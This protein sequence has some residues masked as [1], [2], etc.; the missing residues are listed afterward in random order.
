MAL[1]IYCEAWGYDPEDSEYIEVDP[2]TGEYKLVE[3]EY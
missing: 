1:K 3:L 2:D